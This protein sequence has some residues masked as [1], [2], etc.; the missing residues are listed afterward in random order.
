[1]AEATTQNDEGE[2]VE[3][4]DEILEL[5]VLYVLNEGGQR[6]PPNLSKDKK[7]AVRKRAATLECNKGEVFIVKKKGRVRVV[8]SAEEQR[9]VLVACHSEPTS[10]HF[11]VTK[12][13]GGLQKGS[14]GK[15]WSA[16][17]DN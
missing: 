8:T 1:M 14:I 2:I 4:E 6:Y 12:T 11:G 7:R 10:G 9:K 3:V 13:G 15:V 16:M 5:A 17:S